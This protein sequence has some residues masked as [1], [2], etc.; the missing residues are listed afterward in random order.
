[1]QTVPNLSIGATGLLKG[2]EVANA[3]YEKY[4][5]SKNPYLE[6]PKSGGIGRPKSATAKAR[7]GV[8]AANNATES[9]LPTLVP[10]DSPRI[11]KMP[12]KTLA[13]LYDNHQSDRVL[14]RESRHREP[15]VTPGILRWPE[16]KI[17]PL[18]GYQRSSP[19]KLLDK[20]AVNEVKKRPRSKSKSRSKP[21]TLAEDDVEAM[22]ND[23]TQLAEE[24]AVL[25]LRAALMLVVLGENA[26]SSNRPASASRIPGTRPPVTHAHANAPKSKREL[27]IVHVSHIVPA[28]PKTSQGPSS[29]SPRGTVLV[30]DVLS[31]NAAS[32]L[33]VSPRANVH[34]TTTNEAPKSEVSKAADIV[35]DTKHS[36][37]A[38]NN[39]M[40]TSSQQGPSVVRAAAA[41]TEMAQIKPEG[42]EKVSVPHDEIVSH[43][44][45]NPFGGLAGGLKGA[46][47]DGKSALRKV[48]KGP[49]AEPKERDEQAAATSIADLALR[50]NTW[51]SF[52][53]EIKRI[54][55]ETVQYRSFK[56]LHMEDEDPQLQDVLGK[57]KFA[58][59]YKARNQ[60]GKKFV[61]KIASYIGNI[62]Q[63]NEHKI[64]RPY[65]PVKVVQEFQREIE[66]LAVLKHG[67]V[68]GFEGL[69][70]PPSMPFGIACEYMNGGSLG[71][72]MQSETHWN[73]NSVPDKQRLGLVR[74]ILTGLEYMHKK[75]FV[76][77]D[78]KPFNILLCSEAWFDSSNR[79]SGQ[80]RASSVVDED[81]MQ[82]RNW[83]RA[84]IADFGTSIK[85]DRGHTL[86]DE[87]GTTGY[88][89]PEIFKGAYTHS[90]DV[91]SFAVVM[92]ELFSVDRKNPLAGKSEDK[93]EEEN[94][95]P[96]LGKEHPSVISVL[97]K[98]GWHGDPS[99]RPTCEAMSG[100]LL[101]QMQ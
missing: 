9:T 51:E 43:A 81:G 61:F 64:P 98:K 72:A 7:T 88:T 89:A 101:M 95:R 69:L 13:K 42:I 21:E 38:E 76:H 40:G 8:R 29:V 54:V 73:T 33:L 55:P 28:S 39:P 94:I 37:R 1:M 31:Q 35:Q 24:E 83:T 91:F 2:H 12:L 15:T 20:N 57:G 30:R 67:N 90:V 79:A 82:P 5:K 92:W 49:T 66:A 45:P 18:S 26:R 74:D 58:T 52:M 22:F 17:R 84:K 53:G 34:T 96:Q 59:V 78:I 3:H 19:I 100:L 65:P 75:G 48:Q 77:R 44:R 86:S 80:E 10:A 56:E 71:Q 60:T 36:L 87:I 97:C 63:S 50:E 70:L 14:L 85:L 4:Y 11:E 68:I 25:R 93:I 47:Q 16:V 99:K 23:N 32:A 62:V 27:P 46:L 41:T 6:R